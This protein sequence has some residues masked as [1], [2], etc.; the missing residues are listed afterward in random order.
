MACGVHM[1]SGACNAIRAEEYRTN[2]SWN[3]LQTV[4]AF[5]SPTS[6]LGDDARPST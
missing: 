6:P 5:G 1:R 2:H 4:A 3:A